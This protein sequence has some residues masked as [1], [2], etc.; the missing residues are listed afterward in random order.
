M[1]EAEL[2]LIPCRL[3]G[4]KLKKASDGQLRFQLSTGLVYDLERRI[5]FD[6]DEYVQQAIRLVSDL[7]DR[8]SSALAV[9][10]HFA[11]QHLQVFTRLRDGSRHG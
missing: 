2:C 4:G 11:D 8:S 3:L 6:P 9:V 10:R 5:A 1:S 7:F